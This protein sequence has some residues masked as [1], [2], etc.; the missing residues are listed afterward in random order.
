[1]FFVSVAAVA[2]FTVYFAIRLRKPSYLERSHYLTAASYVALFA[3]CQL[4]LLTDESSGLVLLQLFVLAPILVGIHFLAG[5]EF[6]LSTEEQWK[7]NSV[8]DRKTHVI[9]LVFT[10]L[11]VLTV[12]WSSALH[13]TLG[14]ST[15]LDLSMIAAVE[16]V[17]L[18][19]GAAI[20]E[21][22]VYRLAIQSFIV[23]KLGTKWWGILTAVCI[24]NF[25]W[26]A[27]HQQYETNLTGYLQ[28]LPMG[29]ACSYL[30]IKH[31]IKSAVL[32]H[33]SY[34][35]LYFLIR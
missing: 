11:L 18:F 23:S 3:L 33:F 30:Q 22:V 2:V 24:S 9:F 35:I 21:E 12:L 27:S 26:L 28:I 31:G 34:N 20:R 5:T 29:L 17:V 13:W 8:N 10:A 14:G 25:L 1:M 32:L 16:T 19:V 4:N 15:A 7:N 6:V